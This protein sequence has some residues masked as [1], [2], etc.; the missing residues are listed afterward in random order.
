[1]RRLPSLCCALQAAVPKFMALRLEPASATMLLPG[2]T[3]TQ[4]GWHL[5]WPGTHGV[6][7]DV[8]MSVTGL[9][10]RQAAACLSALHLC[11]S[12]GMR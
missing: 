12:T 1:M 8:A 4:V 11:C 9:W 10:G 3:V 6:H 5:A 7:S 2:A